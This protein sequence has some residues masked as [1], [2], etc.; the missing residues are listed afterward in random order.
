MKPIFVALILCVA[1]T[2]ASAVEPVG[3]LDAYRRALA[4]ESVEC[5]LVPDRPGRWVLYSEGD[6]VLMRGVA[7]V[8]VETVATSTPAAPV[9]ASSGEWVT[10]CSG[11]VCTRVFVPTSGVTLASGVQSVQ[12]VSSGSC[13]SCSTCP[14]GACASG[15][16]VSGCGGVAGGRRVLFPRLRG[17]CR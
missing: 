7:P 15:Q 13:A 5:G 3:Y 12:A 10:T 16:C 11:G 1:S 4:G 9:A 17:R 14:A 2:A 8:P 6:R